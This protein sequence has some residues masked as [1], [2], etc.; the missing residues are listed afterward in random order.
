MRFF[1]FPALLQVVA[2][3]LRLR[4]FLAACLVVCIWT[5]SASA[6]MVVER[7]DAGRAITFDVRAPKVDVAWYASLL[8]G[9]AHGDE[10]S[11]VTFRIVS[12]EEIEE[13]CG[14]FAAACYSGRRSATI[15]VPAG[16]GARIA[17]VLLHEYGHHLDAAWH[18]EGV[19][20][21]NGTPVWWALRRGAELRRSGAAAESYSLGWSRG[22]GEIFAE[23]YAYIHLGNSY[24]I[25]WLYPPNAQLKEA[26][27]AE[28][29]GESKPVP[30]APSLVS[31]MRPV[32]FSK[33]GTLEPGGSH[34]ESFELLG[35]GRRITLTAAVSGV[36]SAASRGRALVVCNGT[37]VKAVRLVA[38]RPATL[39]VGRVGPARCQ[40][41]LVNTSDTSRRFS[42]KLRLAVEPA[43]QSVTRERG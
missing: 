41:S 14:R 7:D 42:F 25:P 17:S 40:A 36:K 26:L 5:G 19:A 34:D 33:S 29:R 22:M 8:R 1:V 13:V 43:S 21:P 9:A 37:V 4:A 18:V 6:E 20:E 2:I 38:G 35:P 32:S 24:G 27:L 12:V 31:M 16:T 10:I 11:T 23:D 3:R 28:L 30:S 15:V 39:D